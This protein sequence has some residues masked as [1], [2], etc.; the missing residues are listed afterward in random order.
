MAAVK[1]W[2]DDLVYAL[3][4]QASVDHPD[5]ITMIHTMLIDGVSDVICGDAL[6]G[7]SPMVTCRFTIRYGTR[8]SY[9]VA[10]LQKKDGGWVID[11]AL[12]VTRDRR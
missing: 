1:A 3:S 7:D 5:E 12:V 8:N 11:D 9:Q 4:A 10:R 2:D 6:P